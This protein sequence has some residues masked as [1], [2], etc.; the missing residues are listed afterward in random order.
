MSR[1]AFGRFGGLQFWPGAGPEIPAATRRFG[2]SGHEVAVAVHLGT[3]LQTTA[4]HATGQV[5]FRRH[6]SHRS[7]TA[8]RWPLQG[9]RCRPGGGAPHRHMFPQITRIRFFRTVVR[10]LG[11]F[12][13]GPGKNKTLAPYLADVKIKTRNPFRSRST[14]NQLHATGFVGCQIAGRHGGRMSSP[15]QPGLG[16]FQQRQF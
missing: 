5:S 9:G 4:G 3:D 14:G 7:R 15:R 6:F 1:P 8:G 2:G 16:L 10:L 13:A 12:H 11:A